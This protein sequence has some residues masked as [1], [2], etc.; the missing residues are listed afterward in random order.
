MLTD[1]LDKA[2]L[3]EIKA[4]TYV[5]DEEGAVQ[6]RSDGKRIEATSFMDA[7]GRR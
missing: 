7:F 3:R 6:L 4:R 5:T 1:E 2:V